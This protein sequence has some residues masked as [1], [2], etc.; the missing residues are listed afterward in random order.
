MMK[1]KQ[2]SIESLERKV[3]RHEVSFHRLNRKLVKI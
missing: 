1:D 3:R 2:P